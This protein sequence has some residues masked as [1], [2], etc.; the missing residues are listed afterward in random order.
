VQKDSS[1]NLPLFLGGGGEAGRRVSS[2]GARGF[3]LGCAGCRYVSTCLGSCL[4]S[5][6]SI[7]GRLRGRGRG[8]VEVP[9]D[10]RL[11]QKMAEDLDSNP[12]APKKFLKRDAV[13]NTHELQIN[14][15]PDESQ[16]NE[17]PAKVQTAKKV[18]QT[19]ADENPPPPAQKQ[20]SRRISLQLSK[21]SKRA[22][23]I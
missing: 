22:W 18:Q 21:K 4:L 12:F 14:E 15:H 9:K 20:T 17:Q 16:M 6:V 23:K 8:D 7:A 2:P 1:P 10:D 19:E 11:P 3:V 5:G 13:Q